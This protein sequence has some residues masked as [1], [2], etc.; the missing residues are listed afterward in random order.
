MHTY[1]DLQIIVV[2]AVTNPDCVTFLLNGCGA[3]TNAGDK[4]TDFYPCGIVQSQANNDPDDALATVRRLLIDTAQWRVRD[5]TDDHFCVW[6]K[7]PADARACMGLRNKVYIRRRE[8]EVD[9]GRARF[10]K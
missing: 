10:P 2:S 1:L 4:P 9:K 5:R 8:L 7:M 6:E 3:V